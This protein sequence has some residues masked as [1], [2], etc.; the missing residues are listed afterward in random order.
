MRSMVGTRQ[1]WAAWFMVVGL[2]GGLWAAGC[3]GSGNAFEYFLP[4]FLTT[5]AIT[6]GSNA[7]ATS[8]RQTGGGLGTDTAASSIRAPNRSRASSS[9]SPCE[10]SATITCTTS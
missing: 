9:A 7:P 1:R 6:G 10:T 4:P 5:G 3:G 2:A 8:G